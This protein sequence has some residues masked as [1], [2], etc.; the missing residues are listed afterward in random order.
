MKPALE[1]KAA[2][3]KVGA[4]EPM[5]VDDASIKVS[6]AGYRWTGPCA[7]VCTGSHQWSFL[8]T[9]S[10]YQRVS[11]TLTRAMWVYLHLLP[12]TLLRSTNTCM[13]LR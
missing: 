12:S 5:Q 13:S 8:A 2:A 10:P 3:E 1:A 9:N 6:T 7:C 11:V 4:E